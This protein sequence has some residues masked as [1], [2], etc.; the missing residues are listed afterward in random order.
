MFLF[1]ESGSGG[2]LWSGAKELVPF[3]LPTARTVKTLR[4]R[5]FPRACGNGHLLTPAN[6]AFAEGGRWRCRACGRERAAKFRLKR[7]ATVF[8]A[9]QKTIG[10]RMWNLRR[11]RGLTKGEL[12]FVLDVSAGAI[13]KWE[14]SEVSGLTPQLLARLCR[15][16][17]V[18]L[19]WLVFGRDGE[20]S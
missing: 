20:V 8:A 17:G 2:L 7:K 4:E 9:R 12:A 1:L 11:S 15:Y 6:L 3:F 5:M 14:N 18:D 19:S 10:D 16:F 13:S